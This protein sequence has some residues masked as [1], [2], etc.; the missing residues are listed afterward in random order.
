MGTREFRNSAR[1]LVT[2]R[3]HSPP[4]SIPTAIAIWGR[5]FL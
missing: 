5:V 4:L 2:C 1:V 3:E